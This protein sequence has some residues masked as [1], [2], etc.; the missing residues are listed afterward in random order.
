M[1]LDLATIKNT[2]VTDRQC[3]EYLAN[4]RWKH[5]FVC[6]RCHSTE[7]W[8]TGESKYKCKKCSYKM[9]VTSGTAF[10]DSHIALNKWLLAIWFL[11]E[12]DKKCSADMLQKELELGSSRTSQRIVR[13]I[14]NARHGIQTEKYKSQPAGK[15][16]YNVEICIDPIPYIKSRVYIISAVEKIGTQAGRIRINRTDSSKQ[17]IADFI[18]SNVE[19]YASATIGLTREET[20]IGIVTN[21]VLPNDMRREYNQFNKSPLYGYTA[22]DKIR[23]RFIGWINRKP[24]GDF[25]RYCDEYC[26]IHNSKFISVSFEE[27]LESMLK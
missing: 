27:V 15:L 1:D 2:L 20:Q 7:A 6:P 10:Q 3:R 17:H 14:K 16:K 19:P 23:T 13:Q 4:T 5:G 18:Q 12:S 26:S 9:S 8:K 21:I 24:P 22:T 11:T 25:D